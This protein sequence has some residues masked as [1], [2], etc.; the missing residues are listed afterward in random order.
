MLKNKL[1]VLVAAMVLPS[2]M[3]AADQ[4]SCDHFYSRSAYVFTSHHQGVI[5]TQFVGAYS[6][7]EEAS[8]KAYAKFKIDE[9]GHV[10][11][12]FERAGKLIDWQG[13][14]VSIGKDSAG[15]QKLL[16]RYVIERSKFGSMHDDVVRTIDSPGKMFIALDKGD[17]KTRLVDIIGHYDN[18]VSF[19]QKFQFVEGS[20]LNQQEKQ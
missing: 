2:V 16:L 15:D 18:Y 3:I 11:G 8:S 6:F 9:Q 5:P 20:L 19:G 4:S 7:G 14:V 13:S 10:S 1:V 17:N 12:L